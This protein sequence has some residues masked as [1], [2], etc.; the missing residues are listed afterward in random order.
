MEVW[1][2]GEGGRR[3]EMVLT[4]DGQHHVLGE[5]G[6]L[7]IALYLRSVIP[8][9][10]TWT[11]W[12]PTPQ[13]MQWVLLVST[14]QTPHGQRGGAEAR[15][16]FGARDTGPGFGH[17]PD[18]RRRSVSTEK[19]L[20]DRRGEMKEGTLEVRRCDRVK[21]L[22]A[23]PGEKTGRRKGLKIGGEVGKAG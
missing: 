15:A 22:V 12:R 9:Q 11:Q 1:V 16:P 8:A 10:A 6:C 21:E 13:K 5:V 18:S 2:A 14:E 19:G 23:P 3:G 7:V 4:Q 17:C 20:E